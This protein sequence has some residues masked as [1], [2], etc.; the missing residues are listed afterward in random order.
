MFHTIS[1]YGDAEGWNI[2][3]YV[4]TACRSLLFFVVV[5]LLATGGRVGGH[6]AGHGWMAFGASVGLTVGGCG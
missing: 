4:F 5:I 1:I 6:P 2:A 3:F